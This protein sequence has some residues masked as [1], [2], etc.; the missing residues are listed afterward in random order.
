M[1]LHIVVVKK[2]NSIII[3]IQALNED[4]SIR[5]PAV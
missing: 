2:Y 5:T 3:I 4:N 1:P